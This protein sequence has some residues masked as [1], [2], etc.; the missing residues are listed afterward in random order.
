MM[1]R[2]FRSAATVATSSALTPVY[3]A[4]L[5]GSLVLMLF[6]PWFGLGLALVLVGGYVGAKWLASRNG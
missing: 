3:L 6:R 2:F 1:S 4:G 5:A